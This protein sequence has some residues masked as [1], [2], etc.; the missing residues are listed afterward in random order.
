MIAGFTALPTI[1]F[2]E[3]DTGVSSDIADKMANIMSELGK[4]MQVL[5][6]THLPQI[7]AKGKEHFMVYKKDTA[8]RTETHI[9]KL[10]PEERIQEIAHMLSGATV[11]KASF[12][13]AK[14]LLNVRT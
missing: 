9:R 13:N 11:T 1:V 12:D 8:E 5:T 6:I 14:E 10:D 7:A 2:D 3:V 4:R